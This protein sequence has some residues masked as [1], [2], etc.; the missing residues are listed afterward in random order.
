MK[1]GPKGFTLL[2]LVFVLFLLAILARMALPKASNLLRINLRS[3]ATEV[4]GYLRGAYEQSIMR[5]ERLRVRF[6]LAQGTYWAETYREPEGIPL[7]DADTKL[8]EVIPQ[9]QDRA[10]APELTEEEKLEKEAARYEKVQRGNLKATRL[11]DNIR[12][13][14]VYV[15]GGEQVMKQGSPW[16][17]FSPGGYAPKTVVYVINTREEVYSV[18]L[19]PLTGRP[20][21]ER[22]EVRPDDV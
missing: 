18:V 15:A 4:A 3:A 17:E 16:V 12:F 13:S 21:V 5:H 11:P 7:L 8:E 19:Q 20:K 10:E 9:L 1:R 22:G 6:D 2:E 14:G